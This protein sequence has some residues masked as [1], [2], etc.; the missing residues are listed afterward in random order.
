[1]AEEH[2]PDDC[3][4][5]EKVATQVDNTE[6]E[7][8]D[9]YAYDDD[10]CEFARLDWLAARLDPTRTGRAL[11]RDGRSRLRP[12]C[13]VSTRQRKIVERRASGRAYVWVPAVPREDVRSETDRGGADTSS[14]VRMAQY[15]A[16]A[17]AVPAVPAFSARDIAEAT[18]RSLEAEPVLECGLTA[19]QVRA[20]MTRELSPEDYE[21]LLQLDAHVKPRTADETVV[22]RVLARSAPAAQ[23]TE[24]LACLLDIA[25]G[26]ASVPLER[27]GHVFHRDCIA[28]WLQEYNRTCPLCRDDL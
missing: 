16:L 14:W 7:E 24:C 28:S 9:V 20:L 18:L 26:D 27:C 1:M 23:A 13:R 12:S 8:E 4:M 2:C 3:G 22:E 19:V 21:L 6:E 25:I 11:G 15:G 10:A 5:E 17:R